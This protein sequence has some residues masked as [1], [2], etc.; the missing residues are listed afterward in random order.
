V[1]ARQAL[2]ALFSAALSVSAVAD[3]DRKVAEGPAASVYIPAAKAD[4][5]LGDLPP[6]KFWTDPWVYSIPAEKIDSG[7]GDLPPFKFWTDPWVFAMPAESLDDGLGDLPPYHQWRESWVYSIPAE[8][9]DSGLGAIRPS[10]VATV[11]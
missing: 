3:P 7:L 8:K 6:F 1:F 2:L 10:P 4:N 5:G 9:I 11:R